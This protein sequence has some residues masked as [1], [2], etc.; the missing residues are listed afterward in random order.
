MEGVRG[1]C[2]VTGRGRGRTRG[3]TR[4]FIALGDI[5]RRAEVLQV[6]KCVTVTKLKTICNLIIFANPQ[7]R[8]EKI[9]VFLSIAYV[10][11]LSGPICIRVIQKSWLFHNV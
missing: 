1:V 10:I 11:F 8:N 7:C 5:N 3:P 6:R 2:G 9:N 4:D